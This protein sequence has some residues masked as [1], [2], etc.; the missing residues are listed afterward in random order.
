MRVCT[1]LAAFKPNRVSRCLEAR[2]TRKAEIEKYEQR[3]P[4]PRPQNC[5]SEVREIRSTAP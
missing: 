2:I 1:A 3:Y 4:S 5:G